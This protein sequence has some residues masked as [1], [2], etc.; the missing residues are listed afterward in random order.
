MCIQNINPWISY[1]LFRPLK[2]YV[3]L[4]KETAKTEKANLEWFEN[5]NR[6][7]LVGGANALFSI[8]FLNKSPFAIEGLKCKAM[9]NNQ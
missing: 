2:N 1:G 5:V 6:R 9:S 7:K 4:K 8:M 3:C